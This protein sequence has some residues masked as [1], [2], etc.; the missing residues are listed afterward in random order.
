M[1]SDVRELLAYKELEVYFL[2]EYNREWMSYRARVHDGG[3]CF[4][5]GTDLNFVPYSHKAMT[6]IYK[7]IE[8]WF[9]RRTPEDDA[10]AI[11]V[12]FVDSIGPDDLFILD[13]TDTAND[14]LGSI[15]YSNSTLV[16]ENPG[17]FQE[18]DLVAAFRRI[19]PGDKIAINPKRKDT[20]RELADIVVLASSHILF[21]QAKDSPNTEES[22]GRSLDRKRR[23]ARHQLDKGMRQAKGAV[24]YARAHDPLNLFVGE[25]DLPV[26]I[27]SRILLS[28]VVIKEIFADESDLYVSC[29]RTMATD[30]VLGIVL[31]YPSLDLFAHRLP[32]ESKFLVALEEYRTLILRDGRFVNPQAFVLNW[33]ADSRI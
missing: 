28:I 5:D 21:V 25:H 27:G 7:G 20:N 31:D 12:S 1:P 24:V 18:R 15:G 22:L 33:L 17:S 32:D 13:R 4:A 6:L 8:H 30:G 3:S 2:D 23:V 10:R 26:T 9:G 29:S 19:F 16:R 14:Y 11:T